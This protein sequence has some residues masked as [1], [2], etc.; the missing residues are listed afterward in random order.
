MAFVIFIGRVFRLEIATPS[1]LV[2]DG[3]HSRDYDVFRYKF[4]YKFPRHSR[5]YDFLGV[6]RTSKI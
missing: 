6:D 4:T 2:C 3:R 1:A 5:D